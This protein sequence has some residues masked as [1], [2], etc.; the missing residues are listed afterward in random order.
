LCYVWGRNDNGQLG[1]NTT[2]NSLIPTVTFVGGFDWKQVS[3]TSDSY[4]TTAIKTDGTLWTWGYNF[5]GQLGLGNTTNYSSPKQVG[6][7]TNWSKISAGSYHTAA[8][9]TDGT[10]WSWGGNTQGAL[11]IGNTTN[12]S[13]PK[14]VGALTTWKKIIKGSLASGFSLAIK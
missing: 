8:I 12:Y 2:T 10:I 14:Q 7:L 1:N 13:S 4:H 3:A 11:G 6:A 5:Y 9:K